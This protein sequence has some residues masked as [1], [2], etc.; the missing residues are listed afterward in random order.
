MPEVMPDVMLEVMSDVLVEWT[1]KV[2]AV[3]TRISFTL[4]CLFCGLIILIPHLDAMEINIQIKNVQ[5]PED[6]LSTSE[7]Q[8]VI[9]LA[10]W[11]SFR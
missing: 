6:R 9:G 8:Q 2:R 11:S 4:S 1:V 10:L 3:G 7:F 5:E